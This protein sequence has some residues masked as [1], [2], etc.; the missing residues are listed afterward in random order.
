VLIKTQES[1][2]SRL[3]A[4]GDE[5]STNLYISNLP[6]TMTESVALPRP[7]FARIKA[8]TNTRNSVLS[9]WITLSAPAESFV[10]P[11]LTRAEVLAL[12]G[13]FSPHFSISDKTDLFTASSPARS[14]K[15]LS[16]SST[17]NPLVRKAFFC[18]FAMPIP[19]LK[20]T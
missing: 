5:N 11:K 4:E 2:N 6:K 19:L 16:R 14:A 18:K 9:L 20:R 8:N 15:R 13:M 10:I 7:L 17:A 1:F 12:H 3:K